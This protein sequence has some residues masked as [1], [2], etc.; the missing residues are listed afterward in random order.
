MS[1]LDKEYSLTEYA[2]HDY[3]ARIRDS[4]I[5]EHIDS[6]KASEKPKM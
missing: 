6:Q 1:Y 5:K 2:L 3:V 4:W